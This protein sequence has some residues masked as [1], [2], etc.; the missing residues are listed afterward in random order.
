MTMAEMTM[1]DSEVTV[2]AMSAVAATGESLTGDGQR[3]G[4]QR[5]SRN[6][7][8]NDALELRHGRYLLWAERVSLRD[9]PALVMWTVARCDRDHSDRR[10]AGRTL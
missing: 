5:E 9:D 7:C 8:G 10:G 3:S 2:A 1:A 4:G 6:R